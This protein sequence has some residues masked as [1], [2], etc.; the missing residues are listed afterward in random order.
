V[1]V[2]W[3]GGGG[4]ERSGWYHWWLS[5]SAYHQAVT[6]VTSEGSINVIELLYGYY[7]LGACHTT[8]E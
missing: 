1:E 5:V 7:L 8:A 2:G 4:I 3:L 6:H